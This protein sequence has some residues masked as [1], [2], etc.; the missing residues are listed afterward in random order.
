MG[1]ERRVAIVDGLRT[2]FVKS[3][4]VFKDMS[5]LDLS[6]AVVNELLHRA[7]IEGGQIDQVVYGSVIPDFEGPNLAREIVLRSDM[8][9]EVD[10]YSVTRACATSTQALVNGTQAILTGDADVVIAG[11]ADSLSKPPILYSDTF[12]DALMA[13]ELGQGPAVEGE[14]LH[15][16]AA[17]GSGPSA[18]GPCRE[19]HRTHHG[20]VRGEDG[21]GER[22]H[23]RGSRPVRL[24]VAHEGGRGV[25]EGRLRRRGDAH[26]G[27][28]TETPSPR[29]GFLGPRPPSRSSPHCDRFST[30]STERS[31][32]ATLL[33]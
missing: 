19:E 18:T 24:R 4:T 1:R 13:G 7:G 5:T 23:P 14:G 26:P 33:H 9:Q 27:Q 31:L 29:T 32:Q 16:G 10:A 8:P 2:P 28:A 15:L 3:G 12:V 25:G 11:G 30:E 21:P 6:A 20:S 17:Q 22:D